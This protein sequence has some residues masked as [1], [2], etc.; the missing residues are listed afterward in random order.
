MYNLYDDGEMV[1]QNTLEE[2]LSWLNYYESVLCTDLD[3]EYTPITLETLD[4]YCTAN[5]WK[6]EKVS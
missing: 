2:I 1:M 5:S 3:Q 4:D 6:V